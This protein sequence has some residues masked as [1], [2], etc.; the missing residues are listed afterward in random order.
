MSRGSGYAQQSV[1]LRE[2]ADQLGITG[3]TDAEQVLLTVWHD[4]FRGGELVW[5]FNVDNPD[6]RGFIFAK[7]NRVCN[8]RC[9]DTCLHVRVMTTLLI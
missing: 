3:D 4:L 8:N 2:A 5:G 7:S 6:L 9:P 1:V